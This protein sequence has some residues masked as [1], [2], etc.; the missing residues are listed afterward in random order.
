M[1]P[2]IIPI[3]GAKWDK[4]LEKWRNGKGRSFQQAHEKY[5]DKHSGLGRCN[6]IPGNK[7]RNRLDKK[8][9]W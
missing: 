7:K 2:K 1:L 3:L 6:V 4:A 8:E 9:T 5:L